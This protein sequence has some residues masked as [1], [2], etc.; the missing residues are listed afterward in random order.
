MRLTLIP[1]TLLLVR[2]LSNLHKFCSSTGGSINTGSSIATCRVIQVKVGVELRKVT[3][4]PTQSERMKI[5][6]GPGWSRW[7][8]KP[9]KAPGNYLGYTFLQDVTMVENPKQMVLG[10]GHH[11]IGKKV[12][13]IS[14]FANV[15]KLASNRNIE[16]SEHVSSWQGSQHYRRNEKIKNRHFL[17]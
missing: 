14:G 16:R 2:C 4:R 11:W 1:Y 15:Q 6:S 10:P 13:R 12:R 3:A 17:V 7:I 8:R 9:R 5:V